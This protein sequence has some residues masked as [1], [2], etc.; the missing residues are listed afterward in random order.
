M[1]TYI[2]TYR[3]ALIM[4]VNTPFVHTGHVFQHTLQSNRLKGFLNGKAL[5]PLVF[6]C[7]QER[8]GDQ[9]CQILIF[10]SIVYFVGE[11]CNVNKD[12]K[13][14][15]RWRRAYL[16]RTVGDEH[17]DFKQEILKVCQNRGDKWA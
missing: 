2:K 1:T 4:I 10:K 14:P 15:A 7:H 11:T 12:P 16:C 13:H 9:V 8:G 5:K 6:L 17:A 3:N